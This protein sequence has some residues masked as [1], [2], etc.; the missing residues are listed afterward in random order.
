MATVFTSRYTIAKLKYIGQKVM[1]IGQVVTVMNMKGGVGKTT[2]TAHIGSLIIQ[3]VQFKK[4]RK[5]LLIDFDPQFNLSQTLIPVQKY[6]EQIKANK[7]V[8]YILTDKVELKKPFEIPSPESTV[9]PTPRD[10]AV[11]ILDDNKGRELDLVLAN[12]EL[13]YLALGTGKTSLDKMANRFK[14]FITQAKKDYDLIL[15]DCHPCGSLLTKSALENS[16]HILIPITQSPFAARGVKI[17]Q[18]FINTIALHNPKKHLLFNNINGNTLTIKAEILQDTTLN[19]CELKTD[20]PNNPLYSKLNQGSNF[21]WDNST[22][23]SYQNAYL[24]LSS[25]TSE[26]LSKVFK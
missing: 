25:I 16:D 12:L 15:I 10:I 13:M 3:D 20:L 21:I 17:M 1:S 22:D 26:L 8:E 7:C 19:G 24:S 11:K 14:L 4:V 2:I 5:V 9:P 6:Y 23:T 18:E